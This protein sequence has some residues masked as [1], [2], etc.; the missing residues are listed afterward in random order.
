M[1]EKFAGFLSSSP[2]ARITVKQLDCFFFFFYLKQLISK[3]CFR[4]SGL[5]IVL[6][7]VTNVRNKE[8]LLKDSYCDL[9][10]SNNLQNNSEP[11]LSFRKL[12]WV[13]LF[14]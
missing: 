13:E 11:S 4:N 5:D 2:K 9:C 6:M 8:C 1:L 12:G 10:F 3:I 14:V 7:N